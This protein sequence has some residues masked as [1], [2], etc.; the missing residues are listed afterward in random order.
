MTKEQSMNMRV[1][2]SVLGKMLLPI[3][4]KS[5]FDLK[6]NPKWKSSQVKNYPF[7]TTREKEAMTYKRM[8]ATKYNSYLDD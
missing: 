4:I 6:L 2:V 1:L 7:L 3:T 8:L 5:Q